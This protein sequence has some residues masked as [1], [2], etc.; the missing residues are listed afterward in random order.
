MFHGKI[1][2]E[3]LEIRKTLD[4]CHSKMYLLTYNNLVNEG[5]KLPGIIITGSS[6]LS[7][8]RL[9]GR[10]ELNAQFNDKQDFKEGKNSSMSWEIILS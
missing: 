9:K 4:P 10:L 5:G 8:Q 2:E 1:L 6:N 7:Y 3:S